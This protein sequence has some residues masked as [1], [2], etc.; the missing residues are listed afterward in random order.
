[1]DALHANGPAWH[2]R[3]TALPIAGVTPQA[4]RHRFHAETSAG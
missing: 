2:D 4:E 3:F 1:V